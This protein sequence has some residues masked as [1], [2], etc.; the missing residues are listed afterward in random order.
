MTE[1]QPLQT[2]E[3]LE[4]KLE[5]TV[6]PELDEVLG[7]PY[8]VLNHG[9]VRVIDY[10]GN[11]AAIVQAARVSYG[12]GTKKVNEDRGLIRYLMRHW[13]TTPFE[14]CEIK[15]HIK[16]PIFVARQWLRHR[17]AN[18]NEYS[19]R[20]S[21]M[22]DEFYL[23]TLE[24]IKPQSKTNKQG[25]DGEL[26]TTD[27]KGAQWL[28]NE[29]NK[30][31][32]DMY[33]A[34][35]GE[36]DTDDSVEPDCIYDLYADGLLTE[37]FKDNGIARES[38][39]AVLPVSNYTQFYYKQ[40]LKNLL[41]FLYLREDSHAQYE[42]RVYAEIMCHIIKLWCPVVYE[43]FRDYMSGASNMSRMEVELMTDIFKGKASILDLEAHPKHICEKYGLSQRELN[44][45]IKRVE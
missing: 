28:L 23:P 13:H 8:E 14:M 18:V 27:K 12:A 4:M 33:K 31:S 38:A 5:R 25:R 7:L 19:G 15:F 29:A 24:N 16:C 37:E 1:P 21:V 44:D 9:F 17:T 41:H 40:D 36:T 10:M 32:H 26:S 22:S 34:L 11:D 6:V 20:Y 3:A 35:L 42:I 30:H 45:F 2:K 39:R 43:A